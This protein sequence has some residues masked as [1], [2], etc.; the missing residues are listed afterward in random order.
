[1]KKLK[2]SIKKIITGKAFAHIG[3]CIAT[4]ALFYFAIQFYIGDMR[5]NEAELGYVACFYFLI[6]V[7]AGRWLCKTWLLKNKPGFFLLFTILSCF[8]LIIAGGLLVQ[9]RFH[10]HNRSFTDFLLKISPFFIISLVIGIFMKLARAALQRQ[11]L[12]AR[13]LAEQKQSELNLLQSQLSPHFLFNTLN[14]MY[15]I[16]IEQHQRIP[17]LLLKLSDLLHYAVYD[18]KQFFVPLKDEL[19]YINN[20]I[21]FEKLRIGEKLSIHTAIETITDTGVRIAPM[22]LIVFIENAFKH[23]KNT[24]EQKITVDIS[25][26]TKDDAI[27]FSVKNSFT[28]N[29]Q[30]RNGMDN[31]SGIGLANIKKRLEL[32]YAGEYDLQQYE[33][34]K[35]Y[36]VDLRLKI[37]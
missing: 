6:C 9:Y 7:Y 32:L 23:S 36:T 33:S 25:L 13:A 2:N 15:G 35:I 37:K 4:L 31:G 21:D 24:L 12:D 17:N 30:E 3:F 20:Y 18:T 11:V 22:L 8:M 16:S 19:A 34:G 1:M 14:N 29:E 26:K 27:F 10:L 28:N 5:S